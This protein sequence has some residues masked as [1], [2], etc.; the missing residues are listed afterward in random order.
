MKDWEEMDMN[1]T[2]TESDSAVQR[3]ITACK[4][5]RKLLLLAGMTP[6]LEDFE[7][8]HK[9][10]YLGNK[11]YEIYSTDYEHDLAKKYL[12]DG[13]WPET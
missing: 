10:F 8:K 12:F 6:R 4:K 9:F 1:Y 3:F 13:T 11:D 2:I 5:K 7:F